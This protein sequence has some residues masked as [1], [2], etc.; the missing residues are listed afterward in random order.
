MHCKRYSKAGIDSQLVDSIEETVWERVF[1]SALASATS[2]LDQNIGEILETDQPKSF[3]LDGLLN[4]IH[5]ASNK[6]LKQ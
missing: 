4:E 5:G 1:I 6:G 3:M 2:Y